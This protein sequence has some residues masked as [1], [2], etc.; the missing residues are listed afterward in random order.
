MER[1]K[2][3]VNKNYATISNV[4]LRD[5]R[6][7]LKAKG[8]ITLVFALPDDWDFSINGMVSI[9][10]EGKGIVYGVISELK[11]CGYCNV[12]KIKDDK[13]RFAD[14]IYQFFEEPQAESPLTENPHTENPDMDYP[15]MENP[16]QLITDS[17]LLIKKETINYEKGVFE[18]FRILFKGKKY[19][20][21]VEFKNFISKSK[22]GDVHLL[23]PAL[24]REIEYRNKLRVNNKFVPDWKNLKTWI[25]NK[26][27]EQEFPEIENESNNQEQI[28]KR[29]GA[30]I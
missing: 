16:P 9:M 18:D 6:L 12:T 10:K 3:V 27:W 2:R 11:Q 4:F 17:N 20:L 13:G 5:N 29:K 21:D 19:G 30:M 24:E 15:D 7:S 14:T 23:L 22:R 25:N 8:F 28:S 26:C 1:I